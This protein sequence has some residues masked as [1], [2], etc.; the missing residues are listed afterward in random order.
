VLSILTKNKAQVWYTD[1][2]IALLIFVIALVI[3]YEYTTNLSNQDKGLLDDLLGDA[4]TISSSLVS[5]GYPTNWT[6]T[7][8]ERIGLTNNDQRIDETKLDAF[9]GMTY[10]DSRK[11]FGTKYDY[12]VFF[13][14]RN[15][16]IT[17][18]GG[19]SEKCGVGH[20]DADQEIEGSECLSINLTTINPEKVVKITRL[21]VYDSEIVKMVV[22]VW[23]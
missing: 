12:F 8:V 23:Q 2:I 10:K 7:T 1:F 11:V 18:I 6:N 20:P 16:D 13:E 22:Y 14:D 17:E 15:N 3:Y 4:K 19:D 5:A 9:L 21:V